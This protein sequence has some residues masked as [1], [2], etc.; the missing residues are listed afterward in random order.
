MA[1][2][3][4]RQLGEAMYKQPNILHVL[5]F[6]KLIMPVWGRLLFNIAG[7]VVYGAPAANFWLYSMHESSVLG[8]IF[9]LIPHRSWW[10]RETPN[11][12]GLVRT[13][14]LLLWEITGDTGSVLNQLWLLPKRVSSMSGV[15]AQ[16]LLLS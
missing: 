4:L 7:L 10:I 11:V 12:L 3:L 9:P 15:L 14:Y 13:V 1:D 2:L 8:L 5:I 6:L 16:G